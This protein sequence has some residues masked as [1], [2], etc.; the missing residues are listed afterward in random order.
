MRSFILCA[1]CFVGC[2]TN[3]NT[4]L[5][6]DAGGDTTAT[7]LPDGG[8]PYMAYCGIE[9][10]CNPEG[11][12]PNCNAGEGGT[13]TPDICIQTYCTHACTSY[14]QCPLP[15]WGCNGFCSPPDGGALSK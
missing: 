15:S 12:E 11:C 7:P 13:A 4:F 10:P 5:P 9:L 14:D 6:N 2:A 8:L 1:L 3:V